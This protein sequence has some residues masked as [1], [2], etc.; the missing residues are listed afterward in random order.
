MAG[1]RRAVW[2]V[3]NER[4]REV[5]AKAA[6]ADVRL[7]EWRDT[8]KLP[9]TATPPRRSRPKPMRKQSGQPRDPA[10]V[11]GRIDLYPE[12]PDAVLRL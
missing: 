7:V 3:A 12:I 9:P 2:H 1:G 4:A 11:R 10:G 5:P 6:R 8:R